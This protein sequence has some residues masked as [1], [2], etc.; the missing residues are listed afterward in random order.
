M[1]K[2]FA[3]FIVVCGMMYGCTVVKPVE[4]LDYATPT[5]FVKMVS[6]NIR[7]SGMSL[8]DGSN[9]WRFRR[10]A[11]VEM[12]KQEVPSMFGVQEALYEQV[13]YIDKAFPQYDYIGVGRD[14]GA[15]AGEFM[16]IFY[17]KDKFQLLES[18]TYWLSETPNEVS[19]GWDAACYRTV[20][21]AQFEEKATGKMF[22]YFN[23]H[24]DHKGEKARRESVKLL[25]NLIDNHVQ[26]GTPVVL[27]GDF[28]SSVNSYIFAPL[29][30]A[31]MLEAREIAPV[32]DHHDTFNGF[33]SAPTSIILDHFFIRD[34][35]PV[36]F[37]T[38][39]DDYGA[40]YISD[41]YPIEMVI[42]L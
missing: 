20:T 26:E 4:D 8:E 18:G 39:L 7:Q 41:H 16:A 2:Y 35:E 23:T 42:K 29:S 10:Q 38:L 33:G 27:G 6:Y 34:A 5:G 12:I 3:L 11:T 40:P 9:A 22:Y 37:R 21:W 14:N 19:K 13:Q 25:V 15:K 36:S 24:L 1:K 17:L 32:T 30:E 31:K 28:N